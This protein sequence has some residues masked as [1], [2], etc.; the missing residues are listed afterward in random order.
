LP[1]YTVVIHVENRFD[2]TESKSTKLACKPTEKGWMEDR[3][4]IPVVAVIG[5]ETTVVLIDKRPERG[6]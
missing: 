3:N 1:R 5:P 6:D 4:G 2:A